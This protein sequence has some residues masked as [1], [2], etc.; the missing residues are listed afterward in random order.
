V[1]PPDARISEELQLDAG[2]QQLQFP[3]EFQNTGSGG[4]LHY[5]YDFER[6]GSPEW[7][8]ENS[9]L[10]LF[11]APRDGGRML[12]LVSARSGENFVTTVGALRDRFLVGSDAEPRDFTFNRAYSAEWT[13]VDAAGLALP[14]T[15]AITG[16]GAA[17]SAATSTAVRMRYEAPEAG[18]AGAAIEKTVRLI[19]PA[20]V[21]ARYRV[22]LN[23]GSRPSAANTSLQ[24]V[25]VSSL[26][27]ESGEDR[28]TQF[29]W[30]VSA[31]RTD[32]GAP[33]D[34]GRDANNLCLGF[35]PL[36]APIAAP[37]GVSHLEIRTPGHAA[38][39]FEWTA[40]ALTLE[41]KSDSV[42]LEVAVAV[43]P[44]LPAETA[45]RYT[46]GPVQ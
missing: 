14:P 42:L 8:L 12:A 11:L 13:D 35:V 28:A 9:A 32:G 31:T 45:L 17:V 36:G 37:A 30:I 2:K 44:D 24:F 23:A 41:M 46:V 43:G 40:G 10:R 20:T 29:C 16:A 5:T 4:L 21:E 1:W 7:V 22:S 39:D 38:L 27:A 15:P 34:G 3:L 26:P 18:P 33:A 19:A 6:D 25:A